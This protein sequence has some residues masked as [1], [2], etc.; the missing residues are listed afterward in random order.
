MKYK[1][2]RKP[3]DLF[4]EFL[5]KHY[6][7]DT[8]TRVNDTEPTGSTHWLC[9]E[10]FKLLQSG[11]LRESSDNISVRSYD[12]YEQAMRDYEQALDSLGVSLAPELKPSP[13]PE[14]EPEPQ[15]EPQPEPKK[16]WWKRWLSKNS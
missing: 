14:P 3:M 10:E 11:V 4:N 7:G 13:Q 15:P 9:E 2:K 5:W 6:K 8:I 1:E 16:A 12:S